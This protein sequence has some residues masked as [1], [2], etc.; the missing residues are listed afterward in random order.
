MVDTSIIGAFSED[1]V[2]R[3]TG[4][5]RGQLSSWRRSGFLRPSLQV[6]EDPRRPYTFLY[7]FKDLL[8]LRV[9]NQLRNVHGVQLAELRRVEA[10]LEKT[11][12]VDA[13]IKTKLWVQNRKVVF[14]EPDTLKK[15]EVYSGQY[16]AEIA[17]E[18]VTSDARQAIHALNSRTAEQAGKIS[19]RRHYHSAQ[20][21][22]AGTRIP[23]ATIKEYIRRGYSVS[24]ILREFPDLSAEDISTARS[25]MNDEAA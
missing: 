12:G 4:L 20:E 1:Q 23:V 10:V 9:I 7:S 19:K 13:W 2:T 3:L 16:V 11:I 6:G 25:L 17:L 5:S 14:H 24:Q 22:F 21:V 8:K 15:R 18:V